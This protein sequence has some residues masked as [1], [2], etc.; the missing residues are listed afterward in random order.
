MES[1]GLDIHEIDDVAILDTAPWTL[2]V[3]TVRFDQ[4]QFKKETT[5]PV[6]YQKSYLELIS[7]YPS[8][9]TIFTDAS[10]TDDGV[11]AAAVSSRNFKNPYA[12]RLPDVAIYTAELRANLDL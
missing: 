9:H 1:S 7:D 3:P 11:A 12:C 8:Y 10:K 2:S 4:T 5:N 6:A